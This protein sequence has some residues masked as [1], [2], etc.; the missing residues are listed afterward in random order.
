MMNA[1]VYMAYLVTMNQHSCS[2]WKPEVHCHDVIW[3]WLD[4]LTSL[5]LL[6]IYCS[7]P[8]HPGDERSWL[9]FVTPSVVAMTT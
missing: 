5:G 6:F 7:V 8:T 1:A 3:F 2:S 9:E 4:S